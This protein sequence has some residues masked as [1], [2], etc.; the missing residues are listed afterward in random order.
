M[1][2][3][4]IFIVA[5]PTLAGSMT[6]YTPKNEAYINSDTGRLNPFTD[7]LPAVYVIHDG[8]R[9]E[10]FTKEY[11]VPWKSDKKR[12]MSLILK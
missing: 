6:G 3:A 11:G 10:G 9:V 2:S 12:T 4:A 1:I 7:I 5:F 8:N